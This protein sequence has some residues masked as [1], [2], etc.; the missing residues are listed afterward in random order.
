MVAHANKLHSLFQRV[1]VLYTN[2]D[3]HM[4]D[5]EKL[6]KEF[7]ATLA[8]HSFVSDVCEPLRKDM[9]AKDH[10]TKFNFET[11]VDTAKL[12]YRFAAAIEKDKNDR[13]PHPLTTLLKVLSPDMQENL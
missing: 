7:L 9:Q 10:A 11:V 12:D 8:I 1:G 6:V 4:V 5:Y 2:I 3:T 13:E